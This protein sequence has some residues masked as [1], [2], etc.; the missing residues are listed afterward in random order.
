MV[1]QNGQPKDNWADLL[2]SE[3][4]EPDECGVA[5]ITSGKQT[6]WF[7][8]MNNDSAKAKWLSDNNWRFFTVDFDDRTVFYSNSES[9]TKT[10]SCPIA[11]KDIVEVKLLD[12]KLQRGL[13][14]RLFGDANEPDAGF[15]LITCDREI[16]LLC[17]V[18]D[19]ARKWVSIFNA[20]RKLGQGGPALVK[21]PSRGSMST[22]PGSD[23]G[24][25]QLSDTD[26]GE[27]G[28]KQ[29]AGFKKEVEFKP[30]GAER[31]P[32]HD[33]P[34]W[35][36]PT[37]EPGSKPEVFCEPDFE[38]AFAALDALQDELGPV[39][40]SPEAPKVDTAT[41]VKAAKAK[42]AEKKKGAKAPK[43]G[44]AETESPESMA[45]KSVAR[46]LHNK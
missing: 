27:P 45:E 37:P 1:L 36:T 4:K 43:V 29:E 38:D 7:R 40:A 5:N 44:Y 17:K 34:P 6:G 16:R 35:A 18:L 28:F 15:C 31:A 10:V 25:P 32:V 14:S 13:T 26:S 20:A 2:R 19:D 23:E 30:Y 39:P 11:F 41:A 42:R 21:S 24:P 46:N 33:L 3:N 9:T 8:K 12:R 22:E